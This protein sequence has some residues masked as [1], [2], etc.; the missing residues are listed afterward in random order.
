MRLYT[1]EIH[2]EIPP[3][4]AVYWAQTDAPSYQLA[5]EAFKIW[6]PK[7]RIL[8]IMSNGPYKQDC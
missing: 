5:H 7:A 8:K 6:K 3:L 4:R 1:F 2:Y